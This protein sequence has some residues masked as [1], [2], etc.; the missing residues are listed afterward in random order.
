MRVFR[1]AALFSRGRAAGTGAR[2]YRAWFVLPCLLLASG[3]AL[4]QA[5]PVEAGGSAIQRA[6]GIL[7][8]ALTARNPDTRKAAVQALGL[9]GPRE[10]YMSRL[11]TMLGDRDVEV[12]VAA[13]SS[14]VDL[15]DPG[16]LPA[17][18]HAYDDP[19]PE[20]SFA[21]ARALVSMGDRS[22]RDALIDVLRGSD[23]A[24]SGYLTRNG[25]ELKRMFYAPGSALPYLT[26]RTIGLAHVSGLGA[27]IASLEGLLA[28]QNISGRATAALMLGT[29]RDPRVVPALLAALADHDP[30]VRASAVHALALRDDPGLERD[31]LPML[32]DH[33]VEVQ[34]RAAAACLRLELLLAEAQARTVVPPPAAPAT[35][36]RARRPRVR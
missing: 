27:G 32:D 3:L 5:T 14:L 24:A 6:R 10:P 23:D 26:S 1:A 36:T 7:D 13:I 22:G 21:A 9:I 12:R 29:D 11:M 15:R 33:K 18:R 8:H 16:V 20:V 35:T 30:V 19:V 4:A 2:R 17:I 31:L 28:D 25:R 34:A